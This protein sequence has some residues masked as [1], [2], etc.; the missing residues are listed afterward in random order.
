MLLREIKKEEFNSFAN[1]VKVRSFEQSIQ[2]GELR[3]KRGYAVTYLGL[4]NNQG[5]Q[6]AALVYQQKILGGF[7]MELYYGPIYQ[8]KNYLGQFLQELKI[9]AK[10]QKVIELSVFPNDSYQIYDTDGQP[11]S[12]PNQELLNTFEKEG[13]HHTGFKTGYTSG[14]I[15]WQYYKDLKGLDQNSIFKSFSK[16]GRPL[17][18][19]AKTFGIKLRRLERSELKL[20]K[21]ITSSTSERRDYSDKSLEY[22]Q[23]FYDSFG[24]S[25]EFV[26]ASLN[27]QEYLDNLTKDQ[28]KLTPK[29]DRLKAQLEVNPNSEKTKNQLREFSNQFDT[30]EVRKAEAQEF[31]DKYGNQ[32]VILAGS[33]FLYHKQE[34]TYLYSGSYTEFNKFYAPAILQEYVMLE[35]IKRDI[36]TYNLLGITGNFD[37]SDGVLRFKQNFNG[38]ISR[39]TGRFTY[40][41]SPLKHKLIQFIKTILGRN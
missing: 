27:F 32:D 24:D 8:D 19:K 14:E 33:L 12:E 2:M 10:K 3:Q 40:Y 15:Y 31:I 29:I 39:K 30:F 9:Y 37:G 20:F 16:K 25:C 21:D 13:F 38:Y 17:I 28:A 35:A 5:I 18:K 6:V 4:K 7:R 11:I 26:V 1:Q 22:Y 36:P 41:P 34:A 23:T